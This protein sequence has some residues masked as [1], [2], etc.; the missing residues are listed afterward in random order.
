VVTTDTSING[1]AAPT[2]T[3][4]TGG[5]LDGQAMTVSCDGDTLETQ[6][7]GSPFVQV[8]HAAS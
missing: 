3:A 2:S 8:W 1:T 6:A 7:T 5:G 4:P